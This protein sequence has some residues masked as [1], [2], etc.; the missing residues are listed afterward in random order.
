MKII[1]NLKKIILLAF[2]A[3]NIVSCTD[4]DTVQQ[5]PVDNSILGI[6]QRTPNLTILY[7]AINKAGL[8]NTLGATGSYT[9]FAPTDDAFIA[10]LK[11]KKIPKLEDVPRDLLREI[12]L[13]HVLSGTK[14]STD[15][16]TQYE[17]TLGKG[18]A[19]ET[20]TLSMYVEASVTSVKLNGVSNVTTLNNI[21]ASNGIIHIVDAVIDLPTIV[22][23]ATAN[24]NFSSLV[25]ALTGAGQP[26]FVTTLSGTGPFTV[27]APDND[28]F[29]AL[30]TELT[31]GI[32]SVSTAN[33]T[34]V[35][36]YHVVQ[37][38]NVLAATLKDKQ[39]ITPILTPAQIFTIEL[40]TTGAQIKD[41]AGRTSMIKVTDVQCSNGVI[42]VL[43]T[44]LLPKLN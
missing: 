22:T 1:S 12:L 8:A 2:I 20:N 3:V 16:K 29:T 28:A 23:H 15:L 39:E 44:V 4:T 17:K 31:G 13:N 33:L 24:A 36:Q 37:G 18:S 42:H 32:A 21:G 19:S 43:K 9:V 35:L 30:N 10:F 27:F 5:L 26:D 6:A 40:P 14:K 25:G 11:V 7:Q 38:D 34:K 41:A